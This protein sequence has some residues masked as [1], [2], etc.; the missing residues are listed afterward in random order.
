MSKIKEDGRY[1][2]QL[3]AKRYA[4]QAGVDNHGT[5]SPVVKF[6]TLQML[7]AL[8]V[9]NDW[10]IE[11]MDL[12]TAFLHSELALFIYMKILEGLK[13]QKG[14]SPRMVHRLIKMIYGLKQAP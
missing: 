5:F 3:V 14:N 12:K 4:Q 10:V 13:L 8:S 2:D 9:E 11:G 1:K 7:L 6:T